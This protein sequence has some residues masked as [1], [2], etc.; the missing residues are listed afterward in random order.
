MRRFV[1]GDIRG[2]LRLLRKLI[3]RIG[4]TDSDVLIFL[5]SYLGPGSDSK[6]VVEYLLT[7]RRKPLQML[8]LKGCYE[9]M[10]GSCIETKPAL[11]TM[12]IWQSMDGA[13]VF[14]S[15]AT[16]KKLVIMSPINGN[17]SS[18]PTVA[19]IPMQIPEAH[20]RFM[21]TDLH[22]WFTDDV[23]P[24]IATHSGGHPDLFGGKLDIEEQIVFAEK[25]WWKNDGLHVTGK[26]V[27]FSHVPFSKPF[28]RAGK[29]GIDLGAGLHVD[30]KLCCFEMF[31]DSFIIVR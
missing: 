26:E 7:L 25:D 1:V 14:Q 6:G 10:F 31:T 15:Y 20:I 24:Y 16:N 8:F 28:R 11:S 23:F 2:D 12:Q 22:H 9:Y 13:K 27:I 29:I 21:E 19:E 30:G 18:R 5:G 3:D 4:P 17:G